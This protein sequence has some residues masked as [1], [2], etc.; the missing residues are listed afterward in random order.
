M[1][2]RSQL[3]TRRVALSALVVLAVV[4]GMTSTLVAA[5]SRSS[6]A[7]S[8]HTVTLRSGMSHA[9]VRSGEVNLATL[10]TAKQSATANSAAPT[11]L[12]VN[13]QLK[14]PAQRAAYQQYLQT[15]ASSLPRGTGGQVS[16]RS[17]NFVGGNTIPSLVNQADGI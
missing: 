12:P 8:S 11:Q 2:W 14:T 15:H 5:K 7:A 13:R 6:A 3:S 1:S 9:A 16:T 4:V 10:P 17:P